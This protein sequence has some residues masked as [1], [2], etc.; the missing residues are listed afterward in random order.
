MIEIVAKDFIANGFSKDNA[1]VLSQEINKA[2]S[3]SCSFIVDFDGV[4]YFTI[5]YSLNANQ[6]SDGVKQPFALGFY[7][8][9]CN[10]VFTWHFVL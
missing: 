4:K 2:V 8:R 6:L 7:Q 1:D 9:S 10:T 5:L 3:K